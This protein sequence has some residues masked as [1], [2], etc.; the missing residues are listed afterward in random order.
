MDER[1]CGVNDMTFEEWERYQYQMLR[2]YS[3]YQYDN[4][5][6]EE[7]E[8]EDDSSEES[9]DES[10][11]ESSSEEVNEWDDNNDDRV[12][13]CD[14]TDIRAGYCCFNSLGLECNGKCHPDGYDR[15]LKVL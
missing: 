3:V 11:D 6:Y 9:S 7:E 5:P 10:S 4:R 1:L 12:C 13:L 2:H 14:P 8:Y 15:W